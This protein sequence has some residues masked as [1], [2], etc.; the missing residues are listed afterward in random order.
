MRI[1]QELLLKIADDT[2]A[3]RTEADPEII[4]A[5]L[6]GAVLEKMPLLGGTADIDMVFVHA[7]GEEKREIV[8]LTDEVHLD[9]NHHPKSKYEA[10][11][12]LRAVPWLGSTIYYCKILYDPKHFL[13][14]TQASV[15]GLFDRSDTVLSRA[16]PWLTEARQMWLKFNSQVP[17]SGTV[18][19]TQYLQA[20]ERIA[21]AVASLNG[22]PL[23]ERRFLL[24][25]PARAEALGHAGLSA[26]LIGLLGA[27]DLDSAKMTAW[28]PAWE[29]AYAAA[30]ELDSNSA[31]LH[32]HRLPYYQRAIEAILA[33]ERPQAALWP[34]LRTWTQA[35][36]LLPEDKEH[37]SAWTDAFDQLNLLGKHIEGKYAGLDAYLDTVEDIFDAWK[38]ERGL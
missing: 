6:H 14:F 36:S 11:R 9:I 15:R 18:Q 25:F 28:V 12:S 38:E 3:E 19:I 5:Y 13:D 17:K 2:V 23:T 21:N 24:D 37:I 22:P 1:T 29:A 32:L 16:E 34:L 20:L 35:V 31:E 4:S 10:A 27:S 30:A 33:G 7:N 8:R 26:G